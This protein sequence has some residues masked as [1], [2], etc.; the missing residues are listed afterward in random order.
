MI[1]FWDPS[2]FL[3]IPGVVL[4]LWAQ[5]RVR[6]AYGRYAQVPVASGVSGARAARA[7]LDA[8]GLRDVAIEEIPGELTDHYDPRDRV[9]RLS[10]PV[11]RGGSV[12]AV[13]I[14]AHEAGHALQHAHEYAP[15]NI[16][17]AII[18]I[19]RFGSSAAFPL[20]FAGMIF[21]MPQ[22]ITLG[23]WLF[24]AVVVFQAVTLPVEFNASARAKRKL[25]ELGIVGREER[26]GVDSVL[27]AAALTYVAA[28][29]VAVLSLLRLVILR[30]S[31]R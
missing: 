23:I 24:A 18:P 10:G 26:R 20:A 25:V 17:M 15:L 16:R 31:R 3:V 7:V 5:H 19:T 29:A 12:A 1:G 4:A 11:A 21:R 8:D 2:I 13:G 27:N 22:L 6:R 28:M 30:D 14:A 9:L